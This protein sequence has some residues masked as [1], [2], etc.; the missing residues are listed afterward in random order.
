MSKSQEDTVS[1][2]KRTGDG[3]LE[4]DIFLTAALR[5]MT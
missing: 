2:E 3:V 4:F 5:A 1:V